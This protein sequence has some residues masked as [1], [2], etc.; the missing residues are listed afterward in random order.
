[1]ILTSEEEA[2]VSGEYGAGIEKCIRLLIKYGEALGADQL[3]NVTSAHVFNG[4]PLDLFMELTEGAEG[5]RAFTTLHPF[6]SLSDP[7][8]CE[9]LGFSKDQCS[10]K[11]SE[12]GEKEKNYRKL[13]FFETYTCAPHLVGN[14]P[15]KGDYI[16][17]FGSSVQLMVNSVFGA[18]QNRDGAV[19]NMAIALTGKAPLQGLYLDENRHAEVLVEIEVDPDSLT[20]IDYGAIGYY[21]GAIAQDRNTLVNGLNRNMTLDEI[22]AVLAPMSTSGGVSICHISGVTPEAPDTKTA[23][24]G[25]RPEET[26][27][28]GKEEI[29][30]TIQKYADPQSDTVDLVIFGCPH[31]SVQ[32]LKDMAKL[33]QEK[34][35]GTN[36]NLWIGTGQQINNLAQTMGYSQ[37]IEKA[38]GII[39]RSCMAT[40]PDCPIPEDVRVV[41]TN[42]FKTAHY[43]SA[44]SKGRIK[45]VIGNLED[46]VYAAI[47]GKWKGGDS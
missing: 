31:C 35:V 47:K 3:V 36:Q 17:W 2:M 43:V 40:L 21:V 18:K 25:K 37:I 6:M 1:M 11:K 45:T 33:L 46:C 8:T 32:E 15:K 42:S 23:L 10:E 19:V 27:Q 29:L 13:N 9:R 24:G 30:K 38:G 26:I 28:V 41:A 7:F 14:I 22:K 39:S 44:L 5:A 34:K 12:H 20:K 16:S 4:Y